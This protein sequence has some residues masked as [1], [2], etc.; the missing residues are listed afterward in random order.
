MLLRSIGFVDTL[1]RP[2]KIIDV[3]LTVQIFVDNKR[4]GLIAKAKLRSAAEISRCSRFDLSLSLGG[5][6]I[7]RLRREAPPAG[8]DG[9]VIVER[10]YALNWLIG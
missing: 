7:A 6:E 8:L 5:Y 10:H 9:G 2:E 3:P 1:E 4:D